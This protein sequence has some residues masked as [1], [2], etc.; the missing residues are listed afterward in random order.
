[1]ARAEPLPLAWA[2]YSS[3]RARKNGG[4]LALHAAPDVGL[5]CA[6]HRL[7]PRRDDPVPDAGV[8]GL[9]SP[10]SACG[11]PATRAA[12]VSQSAAVSRGMRSKHSRISETGLPMTRSERSSSPV[13]VS[14]MPTSR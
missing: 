14:S 13:S 7:A 12:T 6:G 3:T 11:T 5:L 9:R 1:M 8:E 2:S 10:S 4:R